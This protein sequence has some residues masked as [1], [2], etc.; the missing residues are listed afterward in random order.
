LRQVT[1]KNGYQCLL[2]I[3]LL[4]VPVLAIRTISTFLAGRAGAGPVHAIHRPQS[5][6]AQADLRGARAYTFQ[7]RLRFMLHQLMRKQRRELILQKSASFEFSS[8]CLRSLMSLATPIH[9]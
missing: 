5:S 1:I 3:F 7:R 6:V 4:N 2:A 8:A 9:L